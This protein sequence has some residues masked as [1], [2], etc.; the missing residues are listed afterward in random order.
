MKT[1]M[2]VFIGATVLFC[3]TGCG[4]VTYPQAEAGDCV[5]KS[6]AVASGGQLVVRADRG[7]IEVAAVE[8]ETVQVKITREARADSEEEAKKLL[9]NHELTFNHQGDKVEITAHLKGD[10]G[11]WNGARNQINVRFKISVPKKY[12]VD[13]KTAGGAI[14]VPDL[15]GMVKVETAGGSLKI[16]RILGEVWARTGGGR[17]ALGGATGAADLMTSGGGIEV[18]DVGS[19]ITARTSGGSITARFAT[20]PKGD[21]SLQTSGGSIHADLAGTI[22]VE[23]KAATSGG[24]VTTDLPV[25]TTGE[26]RSGHLQGTVNGGGPV[27]RLTTSGGSIHLGKF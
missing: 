22:A 19:A 15:T 1:F 2:A 17:I 5:E 12:N 13:L 6:F 25:T 4:I 23:I 9:Q 26:Q 27:L 24:R 14:T 20:Q 11:F 21:C 7:S 18:T 10:R 3:T 8:S 16:G